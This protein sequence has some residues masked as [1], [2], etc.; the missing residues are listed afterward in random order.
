MAD[1]KYAKTKGAILLDRVFNA[2]HKDAKKAANR[3][4]FPFEYSP[5]GQAPGAAHPTHAATTAGASPSTTATR[6]PRMGVIPSGG[7]LPPMPVTQPKMPSFVGVNPVAPPN[8]FTPKQ[9]Q[10]FNPTGPIVPP[11]GMPNFLERPGVTAPVTPPPPMVGGFK[12]V[13]P[14]TPL[15]TT[16]G[17]PTPYM[18]PG[19]G[20][21]QATSVLP[22]KTVTAPVVAPPPMTAFKPMV[23]PP[24]VPGPLAGP[25]HGA[26]G[27]IAPP[28]MNPMA[29]LVP[30]TMGG[31]AP[32][33]PMTPLTTTSGVTPTLPVVSAEPPPPPPT[34][35]QAP[36][37]KAGH[38]SSEAQVDP[39]TLEGI[40]T[41]F[42]SVINKLTPLVTDD[43]AAL[44]D[45][46]N[47]LKELYKKVNSLPAPAAAQLFKLAQ[48]LDSSDNAA[49][50]EAHEDLKKNHFHA[51][52]SSVMIGLK[53]LFQTAQ[54]F[55]L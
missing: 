53:R 25:S 36:R 50:N 3:P 49:A 40:P 23:P 30:P 21:G 41:H 20:A 11:P 24:M 34:S 44:N 43:P 26:P 22:P 18:P 46:H 51:I 45:I 35:A 28:P 52:G 54:K 38:H 42:E 39:A 9:P 31:V 47:R 2:V 33:P 10:V 48:A 37:A 32:P 55:Q 15:L 8:T 13:A 27:H 29:G 14:P 6:Q 7:N 16:P 17:A 19:P 1:E 5:L 4:R 12:P